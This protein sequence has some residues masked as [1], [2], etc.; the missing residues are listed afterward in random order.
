MQLGVCLFFAG[1]CGCGFGVIKMKPG[2]IEAMTHKYS[3]EK[4]ERDLALLK[5]QQDIWQQE[6]AEG[7]RLSPVVL[8]NDDN[9]MSDKWLKLR[10]KRELHMK[11]GFSIG[12]GVA[13]LGLL[14]MAAHASIS[15]PK[16]GIKPVK[17]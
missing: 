17:T 14:C 13:L 4:G 5:M 2:K 12:A 9:S 16:Q 7:R 10:A 6:R 3:V 1:I 11:L 15:Q 8:P